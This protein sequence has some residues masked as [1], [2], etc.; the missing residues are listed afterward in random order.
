M[1]IQLEEERSQRSQSSS[2]KKQ[3]E[4]ELQDTESQLEATS[5][6]KEEAIKHLKRLQVVQMIVINVN[7]KYS[8]SSL[9]YCILG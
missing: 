7:K 9:L 8:Y 5:R 1:E 6:G 3:L 2:S 4:V